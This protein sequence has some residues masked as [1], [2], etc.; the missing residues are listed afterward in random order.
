[1][2]RPRE[3]VC[4]QDGLKL[5]LNRLMRK[6]FVGRGANIGLYEITFTHPYWG[7]VASG[8][9]S[10]DMT[11]ENEGWFRIQ[12]GGLD[13]RI[14]LVAQS[15][16][17]GGRQWYFLCPVKNR[18]VSVLW[19]PGGATRFCSRQTWGR[20]VAYQSQFNDPTNRAHAGQAENQGAPDSQPRSGRMGPSAKAEMDAVDD[21]Q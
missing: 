21:L 17:F 2:P 4:L 1:M 13:Q 10:A 6:G 11:G 5:D 9:I 7:K 16:H 8:F 19:R 20:Q 3:R 18:L 12:L 14:N 15:R